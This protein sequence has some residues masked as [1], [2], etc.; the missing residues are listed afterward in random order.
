MAQEEQRMREENEALA[1]LAEETAML[2]KKVATS[3]SNCNLTVSQ[4]IY[5][6]PWLVF[7]K[8]AWLKHGK[9]DCLVYA[10]Y[11]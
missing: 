5:S 11:P 7:K 4:S 8:S 3:V 10:A 2:W 9:H 6:W 1:S